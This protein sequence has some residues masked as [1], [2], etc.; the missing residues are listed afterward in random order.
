MVSFGGDQKIDPPASNEQNWFENDDHNFLDLGVVTVQQVL[1]LKVYN[2]N[3]IEYVPKSDPIQD[4]HNF[5]R[6]VEI[7]VFFGDWCKDSKKVVP[8]FLK[9]MEFSSNPNIAVTYI[10]LSP[11]K[12]KPADLVSGWN[13]QSVPTFVVLQD[14]GEVGRIVETPRLTLEEDLYGILASL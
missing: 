1:K 6:P 4:M 3:Y 11:D 5:N 14:G 10:N 2:Y 7:K 8:A 12:K 9:I 13:I